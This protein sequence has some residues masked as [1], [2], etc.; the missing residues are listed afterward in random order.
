MANIGFIG[1]GVMGSRIVKRLL[2]AGH[3]VTGYNRTK[4]KA[5]WL[6]DAGMKW[7][8]SPQAVAKAVDV[9]FTMVSNTSALQAVTGGS[10][11]LLAGLRPGA[12]FVD[13][14]TVSP[15]VIRSLAAQVTSKGAQMLDAPV[16]GSVTTL[17]EGK[18]SIMVGGDPASFE[19]V[20]P[21]LLDIGPKVTRVGGNGLAVSMK[22]ATNLSLAVQMLAFSEAV[23]LAEK[24]GIARETAVEVL[25]NSVIASPMVKYRG[26]FVMGM[27][28]E[29]WFNVNMMQKDMLLALEMGRQ[30]EVPLPTT[31]VTN[32]MLTTARGMG[33]AEKDFA[34]VFE[35]LARMSGLKR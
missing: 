33:L 7:G 4:S 23:L 19:R 8:D 13:M 18:L 11:G 30:F 10:D 2:D 28:D 31:A 12:I 17:E 1:L 5:Q 22:I 35:A 21:I 27:P 34:A 32:E 3:S 25:L 6:L 9:V 24:S 20:Q 16:S 26:P 15:E 14:S 29:A